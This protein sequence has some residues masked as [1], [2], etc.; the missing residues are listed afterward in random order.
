MKKNPTIALAIGLVM[1]FGCSPIQRTH[2]LMK[3]KRGQAA[4]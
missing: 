1:L 4:K 2:S 3:L